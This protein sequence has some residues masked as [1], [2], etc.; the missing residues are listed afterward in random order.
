MAVTA[1]MAVGYPDES[2]PGHLKQSLSYDKVFFNRFG[3]TTP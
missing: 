1:I 2:K 3:K